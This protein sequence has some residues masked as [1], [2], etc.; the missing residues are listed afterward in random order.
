MLS[1]IKGVRAVLGYSSLFVPALMPEPGCLTM[2]QSPV[3]LS[4]EQTQKASPVAEQHTN[5]STGHY[6]KPA[7]E[8][9]CRKRGFAK[10]NG[11]TICLKSPS[12]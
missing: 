8:E 4:A 9:L 10:K 12:R 5:M 7:P 6:S 2:D 3:V 1:G 11:G